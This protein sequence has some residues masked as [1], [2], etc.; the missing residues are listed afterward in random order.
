MTASRSN[1]IRLLLTGAGFRAFS[2]VV[3]AVIGFFLTPF[4]IHGL[5]DKIYGI[6]MLAGSFSAS[7]A[8]LD[9]GLANTVSRFA[10]VAIGKND[11]QGLSRCINTALVIYCIMG[12]VSFCLAC[13]LTMFVAAFVE[14][15]SDADLLAILIVLVGAEFAMSFPM[16][17]LTGTISAKLRYDIIG[18][19]E[20]SF[21]LLSS[22]VT[23]FIIMAGYGVIELG[24]AGLGIGVARGC[25]W[26][27]TT[28]KIVPEVR[29]SP[30]LASSKEA[31]SLFSYSMWA[32][33]AQ[34]GDILRFRVDNFVIGAFIGV[35]AITP[36]A[37]AVTLS[38]YF[39][40]LMI[41]TMGVL[42]PLFAQQYGKGDV[43]AMKR[44]LF[45]GI[46]IAVT[47]GSFMG[48]GLCAW[49]KPFIIRWVGYDYLSA[50]PCLVVIVIGLL[51][52]LWQS[53]VIGVLYG[54]ANHHFYTY[55]NS[56][57]AVSNLV[58]SI[59][60]VRYL[61]I[62]G[63]ALGTC[64][65]MVIVKLV[66]Q[67]LFI[68]KVLRIPLWEYLRELWLAVFCSGIAL[69]APFVVSYYFLEPTYIMLCTVGVLSALIYFPVAITL[70]TTS[71]E[72]KKIFTAVVN[73]TI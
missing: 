10:A 43:L 58:L 47:I 53:S 8:L 66:V 33:V 42:T 21:R 57:E 46:R 54:T 34:I 6:W 73:R 25:V 52:A 31:K 68:G 14:L 61:G 37:I 38:E 4:I 39:K 24:F 41:T 30:K 17:A 36:Y 7:Y 23:I 72:R 50:Y 28:R 22:L 62:V 64:I 71:D 32:F 56:L 11:R 65:P 15:P 5:G 59:I 40:Q 13:L 20:L 48:F 19:V 49:G 16:R 55:S 27:F 60:L 70:N 18:I 45:F 67:P 3:S 51:A 1:L 63:V 69:V 26:Y 2:V 29:F 9:L 44:T 12:I 35:A